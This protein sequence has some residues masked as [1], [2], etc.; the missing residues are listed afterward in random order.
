MSAEEVLTGGSAVVP[1]KAPARPVGPFGLK[2]FPGGFVVGAVVAIA[3]TLLI[4]QNGESTQL[5]W[6]AF[7]F[8]APLWIMLL[9]TL[10]AGGLIAEVGKVV[11]G[12]SLASAKQRRGRAQAKPAA[13]NSRKP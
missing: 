1:A 11:V 5:D 10:I 7:H 6:L 9:L 12:R 3:V 4:I 2:S 13:K 8:E